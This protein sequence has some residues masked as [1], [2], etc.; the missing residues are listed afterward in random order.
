MAGNSW[1]RAPVA[2]Q[3]VGAPLSQAAIFLILKVEWGDEALAKV[4]STLGG[5]EGSGF[6]TFPR[7]CPASSASA[8]TYGIGSAPVAVRVN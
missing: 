5:L 1:E 7:V 6:A 2:A 3:S 8:A 4:R